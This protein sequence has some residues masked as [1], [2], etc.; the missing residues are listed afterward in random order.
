M[1][2]C[3][4]ICGVHII[5]SGIPVHAGYLDGVLEGRGGGGSGF[6]RERGAEDDMLLMVGPVLHGKMIHEW[7]HGVYRI[8]P[9]VVHRHVGRRRQRHVADISAP[10]KPRKIPCLWED[11]NG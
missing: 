5:C 7:R 9:A 11:A 1:H 3:M 6:W 10:V 8:A 4:R 2:A